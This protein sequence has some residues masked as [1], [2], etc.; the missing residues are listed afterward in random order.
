MLFASSY[1]FSFVFPYFTDL[2]G[3]ERETDRSPAA[4]LLQHLPQMRAD[5]AKKE[6][7]EEDE[8]VY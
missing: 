8:D 4:L 3:G 7:E 2:S 5:D 1:F 6:E